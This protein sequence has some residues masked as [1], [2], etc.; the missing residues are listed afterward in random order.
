MRHFSKLGEETRV[1][2]IDLGTGATKLT[3]EDLRK[4]DRQVMN[5]RG[6]MLFARALVFFEGDTEEQALPDY[7]EQYWG[8]HPHDLG[9]SFIGVG[10]RGN[11]LPFL[12]MAE[13][14]RI[15]WFILSDGE[16]EAVASVNSALAAIGQIG[17]PTNPRV[18][19][20]PDGKDFETC[21]ATEANRPALIDAIVKHEAQNGHHEAALKREWAAKNPATQLTDIVDKLHANKTQYGS[22]VGKL[23]AV[24]PELASVFLKIDAEMTVAAPLEAKT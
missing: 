19:V 6:D 17:I 9:F 3:P 11:Y 13:S 5:T 23:L 1:S 16:P 4:I 12:R 2:R 20:I 24:P 22:I 10:G 14:F 8:K 18:A 21:I 7:A 15:P